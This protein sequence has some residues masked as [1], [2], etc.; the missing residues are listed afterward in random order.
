MAMIKC[1]N[2]Q[3]DISDKATAC[4]A[5]GFV[6]TKSQNNFCS[7]CGTALPQGVSACP[8]CGCPVEE[9]PAPV[10]PPQ[11][12]EATLNKKKKSKKGIVICI[13]LILAVAAGSLFYVQYSK[14][15]ALNDYQN[16]F[17]ETVKLM[18]EGATKAEESG[19]LIHDVWYNTIFEESNT[20]TDK[21]TKRTYGGFNDD[22]NDSL[23]NLFTDS[24][25]SAN[26]ALIQSNQESVIEKMKELTNPPDEYKEAYEVLK[27]CYDDY[28]TFTNLVINPQG[29][30]TSFT[31][32]YNDADSAVA[33]DIESLRV[34][35]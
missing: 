25:F 10:Q 16:T 9:T 1:P 17:N 18:L 31:E 8:N 28:L 21:Y 29:N 32:N 33:K 30:L 35:L 20:K 7:E 3:K 11:Q 22:F 14:Q 34:Y 19:G 27:K 2:C 5:C 12:V 26:I 24:T 6:I 13:I 4:P 23:E 15:K